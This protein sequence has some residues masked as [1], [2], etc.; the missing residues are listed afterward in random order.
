[1]IGENL[2]LVTDEPA[3]FGKQAVEVE[4]C[5]KFTDH[6]IAMYTMYPNSRKGNGRL[7]CGHGSGWSCNQLSY[8]PPKMSPIS[9][10]G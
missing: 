5:R 3:E 2:H 7:G 1:M 6:F 9:G 10:G 8:G 4:E